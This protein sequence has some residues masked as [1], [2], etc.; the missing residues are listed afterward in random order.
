MPL[1]SPAP[2]HRASFG[3]RI[4]RLAAGHVLDRGEHI[5]VAAAGLAVIAGHRLLAAHDLAQS[6]TAVILAG[7]A[8][9]CRAGEP[10]AEGARAIAEAEE[11]AHRRLRRPGFGELALERSGD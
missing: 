1:V 6:P 4:E 10:A 8:R 11:N 5:G 7:D 3:L 2:L 9:L